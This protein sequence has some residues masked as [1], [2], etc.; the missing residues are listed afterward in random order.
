ML[1][2][3]QA[4][5]YRAALRNDAFIAETGVFVSHGS[6]PAAGKWRDCI[7]YIEKCE[8]A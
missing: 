4:S 2:A 3:E 5:K 7:V 8:T 1:L 6:L